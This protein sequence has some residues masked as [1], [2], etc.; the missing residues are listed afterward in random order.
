MQRNVQ[1]PQCQKCAAGIAK[2]PA[3]DRGHFTITYWL[4]YCKYILLVSSKSS[5]LSAL[6]MFRRLLGG[7]RILSVQWLETSWKFPTLGLAAQERTHNLSIRCQ[8][9][10]LRPQPADPS[11]PLR[12]SVLPAALWVHRYIE[13][14][15]SPWPDCLNRDLPWRWPV[16]PWLMCV[17]VFGGG[18][19]L[20][21]K[22]TM[23]VLKCTALKKLTLNVPVMLSY[24]FLMNDFISRKRLAVTSQR[25][26]LYHNIGVGSSSESHFI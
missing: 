3:A 26:Y 18:L 25:S 4:L 8:G 11:G 5:S 24:K 12:G 15:C 14:P 16:T 6:W 10:P 19:G 7:Q 17:C 13:L 23:W 22:T 20:L 21:E 2:H 1:V 9:L